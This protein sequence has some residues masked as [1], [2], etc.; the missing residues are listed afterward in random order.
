MHPK[1]FQN[2]VWCLSLLKMKYSETEGSKCIHGSLVTILSRYILWLL[3]L[4][5][6]ILCVRL[7]NWLQILKIY[8]CPQFSFKNI[9]FYLPFISAT[10][11]CFFKQI[12]CFTTIF[13]HFTCLSQF[14]PPPSPYYSFLSSTSAPPPSTPQRR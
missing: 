1:V 6:D 5:I 3:I 4:V 12:Y 10:Q 8:Y 14:P 13:Y 7:S 2:L 9:F 11:T